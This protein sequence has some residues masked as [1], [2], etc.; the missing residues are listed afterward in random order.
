VLP[1]IRDEE[2]VLQ[3]MSRRSVLAFGAA[4]GTFAL[5]GCAGRSSKAT[6]SGETA[7]WYWP[8]GLSAAVLTQAAQ[9]FAGRTSLKPVS[10]D[11]V[12][13]DQLVKVLNSG[14]DV[15]AIVGIKGEDIASLL[16][17]AD[18]FADLHVLG[19]D[20]LMPQY[21]SWKWQQ[22][23]APDNRLIGFPIDIGPTA[24]YYRSDLF[25]KAGLPGEPAA[26]AKKIATWDD[27]VSAGAQLVKALPGVKLVRNAAELYTVMICQGTS[28]YIDEINHY[29]GNGDHIRQCWDTS[30]RIVEKKLGAVIPGSEGDQWAKALAAGTVATAL[31]A[32]WLMYDIK[33]AAPDLAGHWRVAGGPATGANY[34]GSFLAIPAAA[35]EHQ[36]SFEIITWLLSPANQAQ[37]FTDA[38]LF[39]AAP[40]SFRMPA[41]LE[42]DPFF[43]GQV[44]VGVFADSAAKAHRV[45]EAPADA[46]IHQAFVDQLD[47]YEKG[48]KTGA[49]AYRDA[50]ANGR[51]IA[52]SMGVN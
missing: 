26:V 40:A 28:R 3:R 47:A 46:T 42:P 16:P 30:A 39:P 37:A 29:V 36:L 2:A 8:G 5:T 32:A 34:G 9:Q 38:A 20:E 15:P 13:R 48:T 43:G 7:L 14:D 17:R 1:S 45:Y 49:K 22:A 23:S 12:Y 21:V 18:L 41:L 35:A 19:V 51:S 11:G 31:G 6:G 24:M 27:Y 25:A 33:N 4:C 50:V 44:T 52:S 10:H